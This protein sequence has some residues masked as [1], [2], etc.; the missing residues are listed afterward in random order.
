MKG[1][2][3]VTTA[4][5]FNFPIAFDRPPC[6]YVIRDI[7]VNGA[8]NDTHNKTAYLCVAQPQNFSTKWLMS[9]L[10]MWYQ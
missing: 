7:F 10:R 8:Y 5:T 9:L 2:E 6:K 4:D 3:D 1:T